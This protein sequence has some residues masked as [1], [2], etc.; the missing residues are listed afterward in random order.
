MVSVIIVA[1]SFFPINVSVC[2]GELFVESV[3]Y[4]VWVR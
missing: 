2:V 4:Y 3:C 1:C